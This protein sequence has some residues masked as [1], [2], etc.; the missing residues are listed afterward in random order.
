METLPP[1][2]VEFLMGQHNPLAPAVHHTRRGHYCEFSVFVYVG[3]TIDLQLI[4]FTDRLQFFA[5]SDLLAKFGDFWS[6]LRGS[7]WVS[8]TRRESIKQKRSKYKRLFR[9]AID[10][11]SA[12]LVLSPVHLYLHRRSVPN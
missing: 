1:Q 12:K 9:F 11:L 4:Q 7:K 8:K 10:L 2:L 5:S 3:G 6:M